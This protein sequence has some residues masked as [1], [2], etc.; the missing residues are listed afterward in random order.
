VA[1]YLLGVLTGVLVVILLVLV[2]LLVAV[3]FRAVEPSIEDDSVLTIE[4]RGEV[5]EHVGVPFALDFFEQRTPV[6]LLTIYSSLKHAATDERIRAVS[7]HADGFA[8]GW[9]KAQEIRWALNEFRRSGKPVYAFLQVGG[10]MDY[11]VASAADRVFQTPEGVL[12]VKGLRA[13]VSF[14]KDTLAKLGVEAEMLRIGEYKSA[15]EPLT[16]SGMSEAFR[17]VLNSVL[18]EVL[19][20]FLGEVAPSREMSVD[21]L[22]EAIDYGPFTAQQALDA[23]LVDELA[24]E[25]EYEKALREKLEVEELK[26]V[27]LRRYRKTLGEGDVYEDG[28][29]ALIYA[30][31]DILRGES[32]SDPFLGVQVLGSDTFSKTAREVRENEDVKSV[33]VRIDSGGGDAIASDQMWR[34]MNLL[35][36]EKPLIISMSDAAASG[37][38]YMAMSGDPVLAYPGTYTGSIGVVLGKLNL[39]GFYE[40]I[41]LNKEI[42]TRGRFAAIDTTYRGFTPAER[43]KVEQGMEQVYNAFVEKVAEARGRP[44][45]EIDRLARGRLWMGSQALDNGLVDEIGGFGRAIER[46]KIAA[47]ID[48]QK[49][50]RIVSYPAPKQWFEVLFNLD[51]LSARS[52]LAGLLRGYL[53]EI[54]HWPALLEGGLLHIPP[55]AV[56]VR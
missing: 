51:G 50:V 24:Y 20:G 39:R 38:Y 41:G 28:H 4:L 7:L 22:R 25:D 16:R 31:G 53:G 21:E 40:K 19:E 2:I 30:V 1:K 56:A 6:T 37:G 3:S 18:D 12:N 29:I 13:E 48:P 11:F 5:P 43:Q 23:G 33:I 32:E 52:R 35:G 9:G 54:P 55:Y 10:T 15:A 14:Y 8:G 36:D 47:G 17:E 34:A 45:R 42:L 26:E 49:K 46:A 27:N 44:W